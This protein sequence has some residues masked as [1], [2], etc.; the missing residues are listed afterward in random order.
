MITAIDPI[1]AQSLAEG[2]P[3]LFD[4]DPECS[5]PD[6]PDSEQMAAS[7]E[8]MATS[9]E[10]STGDLQ[11]ADPI[12]D[13]HLRAIAEPIRSHKKSPRTS[14]QKVIETMC[15]GRFLDRS[16]GCRTARKAARHRS[17]ALRHSDDEDRET[18]NALPRE[19]QTP[20]AGVSEGW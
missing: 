5:E 14:V 19:S 13:A 15:D 7:S 18:R 6:G 11:G 17:S 12:Q 4:P 1:D 20:Q 8:Q 2:Q 16:S 10:Q 9:S 3:S